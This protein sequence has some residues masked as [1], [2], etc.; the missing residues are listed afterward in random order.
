MNRSVILVTGASQ[1]L[2]RETAA[3]LAAQGY[4]VF[5]TARKPSAE[6]VDGVVMLPL[7]V[8]SQGSVKACVSGCW[9]G[10]GRST[11]W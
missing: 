4:Q 7:D 9:T 6:S 1:G 8:T 11:S 5:G 10:P 3:L 2:G